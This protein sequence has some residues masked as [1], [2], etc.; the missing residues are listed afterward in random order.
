M[1]TNEELIDFQNKSRTLTGKAL[2]K[3]LGKFDDRLPDVQNTVAIMLESAANQNPNMNISAL[4]RKISA[5]SI[6]ITEQEQYEIFDKITK[7]AQSLKEPTKT[8]VLSNV[9]EM[10]VI[11]KEGKNGDH[12][13]RKTVIKYFKILKFNETKPQNIKVLEKI[14]KKAEEIPSSNNDVNAFITHLRQNTPEEIILRLLNPSLS[15]ADHLLARNSSNTTIDNLIVECRNCN[16]EKDRQTL[17][18]Q[19][20]R[21]P[22]MKYN[23]Q[24]HIDAIIDYIATNYLKE[25]WDYPELIRETLFKES[26]GKIKIDISRHLLNKALAPKDEP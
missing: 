6:R 17:E 22:E 10:K 11:V 14:I 5:E 7:L 3:E 20:K 4:M 1:T 2:A 26:N 19:L 25:F 12:F 24:K 21:H 23:V 16:T 18:Q 8:D 15:S 9:A 13:R